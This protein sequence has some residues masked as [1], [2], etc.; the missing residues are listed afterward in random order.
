VFYFL[1]ELDSEMKIR[2]SHD[3]AKYIATCMRPRSY[4][5][6]SDVRRIINRLNSSIKNNSTI[7][8]EPSEIFYTFPTLAQKI[9]YEGIQVLEYFESM[10]KY[11]HNQTLVKMITES[12]K[13]KK[14]KV[15]KSLINHAYDCS[16][17]LGK[18]EN[19]K[20]KIWSPSGVKEDAMVDTRYV[21][22]E[23][24]KYFTTHGK[25]EFGLRIAI[26]HIGEQEK[27]ESLKELE[28][29]W[30]KQLRGNL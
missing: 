19:G 23:D 29:L 15:F 12:E 3:E 20:I 28:E 1:K 22:I 9:I 7:E 17:Q 14:T 18:F 10:G 16:V 8:L 11:G 4:P 26:R 21:R 30:K 27:I 25:N 5:N 2:L 13:L 24:G 6:Y